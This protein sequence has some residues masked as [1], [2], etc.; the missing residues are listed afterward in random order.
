MRVQTHPTRVAESGNPHRTEAEEGGD[1]GQS[2]VATGTL[3]DEGGVTHS[4]LHVQRK[5][6]THHSRKYL[7]IM[8][9]NGS[10]TVQI[11]P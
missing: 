9:M 2:I 8:M 11:F 6:M 1:A 4:L 7:I 10:Y 5:I 3:L